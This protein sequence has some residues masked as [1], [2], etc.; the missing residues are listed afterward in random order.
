MSYRAV[1]V[2]VFMSG[3]LVRA[4]LVVVVPLVMVVGSR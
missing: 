3:V 4:W 1:T 2:A